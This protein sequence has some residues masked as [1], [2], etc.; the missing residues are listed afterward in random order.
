MLW[1]PGTKSPKSRWSQGC[2]PWRL[3]GR[4]LPASPSFG[5]C[6]RPLACGCI[7]APVSVCQ[8]RGHLSLD[9]GPTGMLSL[10]GPKLN[11]T[12]R[13]AQRPSGLSRVSRGG[14]FAGPPHTRRS[15]LQ[16]SAHFRWGTESETSKVTYLPKATQQSHR[17]SDSTCVHVTSPRTPLVNDGSHHFRS[18]TS[19]SYSNSTSCSLDPVCMSSAT[20]ARGLSLRDLQDPWPATDATWAKRTSPKHSHVPGPGPQ[21]AC[22]DVSWKSPLPLAVPWGQEECD[23]Q[24][25]PSCHWRNTHPVSGQLLSLV[26]ILPSGATART[27]T[28]RPVHASLSSGHIRQQY[29][30]VPPGASPGHRQCPR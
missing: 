4:V 6:Q 5:G 28:Q 24:D 15:S 14:G 26:W 13:R 9:L 23:R 29:S 16:F 11:S 10:P 30:P 20:N 21:G 1:V 3:L 2:G 22:F 7:T 12:F 17:A 27:L 8:L 25:P 19:N 18:K